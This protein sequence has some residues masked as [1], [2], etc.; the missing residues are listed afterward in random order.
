MTSMLALPVCSFYAQKMQ[1]TSIP[2]NHIE[3]DFPIDELD[4][5]AWS[6]ASEVNVD[7]YWSGESAPAS[8]HFKAQ[9]LWSD[10]ALYVRFEAA[11]AEP[12][13]LTERPDLSRKTMNLWDR[14]VCEIFVA[15]DKDR[16]NKYYEFEVAPTGE[17]I[18]VGIE[19]LPE[20]RV[21]D[22]E[23]ASGMKTATRR[24]KKKVVMAIRIE[25]KA[26]GK[27]PRAGDIW[28]GNLFRCVGRGLG[29]GYLAW[30]PTLTDEPAFHVPE[31]FGE[32]AF[33]R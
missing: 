11:Q 18:D 20:K 4:N 19:V 15:P 29:R 24:E 32:F 13:V 7:S 1:K 25:W 6:K 5:K 2:V 23:Y 14:D 21:S 9:L 28:L 31:K 33:V 3:S 8:R 16:S 12:L 26:F 22:W 30:L 27:R 10:E 17:W